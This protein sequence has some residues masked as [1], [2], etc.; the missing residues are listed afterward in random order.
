MAATVK[1]FYVETNDL[2][3]VD[4]CFLVIKTSQPAQETPRTTQGGCYSNRVF[5]EPT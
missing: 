2:L 5:L 4:I 1:P 3:V